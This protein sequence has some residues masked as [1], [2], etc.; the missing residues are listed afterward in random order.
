MR[1]EGFELEIGPPSVIMKEDDKG[2]KL[3]PFEKVEVRVPEEYVGSV[4]DMFNNRQGTLVDMGID[5]GDG[6]MS[7]VTYII[8]TRG[9]LGLRSGLLTATRGTVIIDSVFDEYKPVV[10]EIQ[11]KEKGSLLAF[12]AG[13]SNTFG[14]QGAQDRGNLFIS[15]NDEVY[16]G[17]IV[18]IHQ[19]PSDLEVNVCKTK[20]L[21]N[22][23]SAGKDNYVGIVPPLELT[24]DGAVEYLS[25]DEILEVTPTKLRMA[26]NPAVS[27][28]KKTGKKK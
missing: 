4:V 26:K 23:R 24:L 1:R 21:T 10:K 2:N 12:S 25:S 27:G 3:E 20:A 5:D 13:T 22:M 15:P 19:R 8:P 16:K 9:M 7:V 6:G 11:G 14:I 18:G 28:K 17:M